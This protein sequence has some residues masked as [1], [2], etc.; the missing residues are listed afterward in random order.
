MYKRQNYVNSTDH[1]ASEFNEKYGGMFG[2]YDN[3]AFSPSTSL[4]AVALG[5]V[6]LVAMCV[7]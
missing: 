6:L 2:S 4:V 3:A 7:F 5:A 1:L